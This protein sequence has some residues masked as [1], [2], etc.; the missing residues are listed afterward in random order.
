MLTVP[1]PPTIPCCCCFLSYWQKFSPKTLDFLTLVRLLKAL[2]KLGVSSPPPN[3]LKFPIAGERKI[4][5]FRYP[6]R[7]PA[8]GVCTPPGDCRIC[9]C[10]C[11]YCY[12]YCNI[13]LENV[14]PPIAMLLLLPL[15]LLLPSKLNCG[16]TAWFVPPKT[17]SAVGLCFGVWE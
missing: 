16:I 8:M 11:Y 10:C 15:L 12:W 6:F 3:W 2:L 4:D 14:P 5:C 9:Y 7:N 1:S 17:L 13:E